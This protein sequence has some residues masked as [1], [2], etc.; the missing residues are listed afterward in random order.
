MKYFDHINPGSV[1]EASS[2]LNEGNTKLMAG[3][4]DLLGALKEQILPDY[5]DRVV[6]LKAVPGLDYIEEKEDGIHIGALAKLC[7]MKES[8][9]LRE[10]LPAVAQAAGSVASPLIR[11]SATLGGNLFQE[12]RCWYYRCASQ[13]GGS[14]KCARKG[15]DYCYAA[16]GENQYHSIFGGAKVKTTPCTSKCP[17]SVD[18]SAY[19]ERLRA[20]DIEGAAGILL[21]NNP[22]PSVTSRV[23][24]H[25]CQEGCSRNQVDERVGV[26]QV[27]R[28][29]GDYILDHADR[30]MPAPT[31]ETGVHV[32]VVGSG[33]AGLSAAFYLRRAG[34]KVTVYE[35]MP[36]AGGLLRYAIPAYRLPKEVVQK[37]V[38]ALE[39]MG[40]EF[41]CGV[42]V[43][44]DIPMEKLA[45]EHDKVFLAPGAWKKTVIGIDGEDMTRF[46]LEF[47]VEVKGWMQNKPGSRVVVV[48]GGNVAVDVAV[49]AKRLG[50]Q[51]VTM[52]SLESREEL[53]ATK[54]ELE[55][56]EEEGIC[57]MTSW[58]PVA[59]NRKDEAVT[60]IKLRRCLSVRDEN[61]RFSPSYDD[62]D[63]T[64]VECDSILLCVGQ[65]TD[66]SFLGSGFALEQ[67]RGRIV[68]DEKTQCTSDD[69][70]YAGGDVVT[71]PSTVVSALAA[72]RR[73]AEQMDA[74]LGR[75]HAAGDPN[76]ASAA[77]GQADAHPS[78]ADAAE[79]KQVS[80]GLR[81]FSPAAPALAS[82][83]GLHIRPV[84]EL[85]VDL[86]DDF[87]LSQ[88][89]V[90]SEANRC[91]NCGCLA[92]NPSDL[93]TVLVCLDGEL[94]TNLRRISAKD[95]FCN[96]DQEGGFL[97]QGEIMTE[98]IL[99][100]KDPGWI[101]SYY[102]FRDRKSIDFAT[103]ALACGYRLEDGIV[104]EARIVLGAVA[105][106]PMIAA[107]AE[108]YLQGKTVDQETAE[109]AAEKALAHVCPME[110]NRY[111]INIAKTLVK[112]SLLDCIK[113]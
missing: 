103:V 22:I 101:T 69:R 104:K 108:E 25:F 54:E 64:S 15:G 38:H 92:V 91:L 3:G 111:K 51:Q 47:L 7:D 61:G 37:L 55:R 60:G 68:A 21:K 80:H 26:G 8:G 56:A 88:E 93:A 73:A 65:Q 98:L 49:T 43:G 27:E 62:G 70:V 13:V 11:N 48:G 31:W 83:A 4:T 12:V 109:Q 75:E 71:G 110:E 29:L 90:L 97:K 53:P 39:Q 78:Q 16:V 113:Q 89:E 23:C 6:N 5:P 17:A 52:V 50:A 14:I 87:G 35:K 42:D 45:A 40:V 72:G 46:G 34:H 76:R 66:L 105:P 19:M 86:E 85:A 96:P 107:E 57:L 77:E 30:L 100:A 94:V 41:R 9:L 112:R 74:A 10:K 28:F 44:Q 18:I 59:V 84:D 106:V 79:R 33:P 36:E 95:L 20:G 24:T 63:T 1:E 32:A 2:L 58:G 102:K 99:P 67:N 82:T 81:T